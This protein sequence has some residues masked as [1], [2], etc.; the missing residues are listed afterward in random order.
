[1]RL[2]PLGTSATNW[3]VAPA[4]DDRWWW[5]WSSRRNENWQGKPKYSE[6]TY[7]SATLFTI[8]PTWPDLGLNPGRRSGKPE[9]TPWITARSITVY[10]KLSFRWIQ[11]LTSNHFKDFEAKFP[12]TWKAHSF[13]LLIERLLCFFK[14]LY[15]TNPESKVCSTLNVTVAMTSASW[16]SVLWALV[17]RNVSIKRRL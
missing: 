9:S 6:K 3:P 1:V 4:P 16:S 14:A 2:S 15:S 10:R 8:N 12:N 13:L 11:R 5:M 7:P 17:Q